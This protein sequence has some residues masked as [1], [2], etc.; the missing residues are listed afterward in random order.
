MT[1][2]AKY[3]LLEAPGRYFDG[4]TAA[5]REVVVRFGDASLILMTADDTPITHWSLAGLRNVG[6]GAGALSLTP[7]HES[8]ERLLITDEYMTAAIRAV[9]PSLSERRKTPGPRWRKAALWAAAALGSIYLIIF[10]LAPALSDQ[11]AELIPP[12]AEIAMG[13]E[14][15]RQFA[16]FIAEGEPR[17]CG[18]GGGQGG[19]ALQKL[20]RRVSTGADAHVPLT[21]RVFDHPMVN[22]FA[23]PGGQILLFRGMIRAADSP[24]AVAGVLAHEIGHV[25]A[26][27]PTRLTLRSAGTAGLI[28]L[29]L[30]DFTGA[31][32]TVALSEALLRSG[33]QRD[34]ETTA[35]GFAARLLAR[36][37][38]PTT[39]LA[40]FFL[41]LKAQSGGGAALFSH[42]S[43]HPD[44][45]GRT[46]AMRDADTIGDAP[47]EPALTDQEWVA[48]RNICR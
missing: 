1:A 22:A 30:G 41:S 11:L 38:L 37:G 27:D 12:E 16:S 14:M 17:F 33:Y 10:H 9:C 5:A 39:P 44:L 43:S 23:L 19:L 42:L 7:D 2:L 24:E 18:E 40:G 32:V 45:D 35:D 28:G 46:Q 21:V 25:A 3:E 6:G 15:A 29:L 31:T 48:L 4:A 13:E 8:D 26:R 20:V 47:Y 36:E 34:A